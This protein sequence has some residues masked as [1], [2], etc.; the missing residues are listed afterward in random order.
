MTLH[1]HWR[2]AVTPTKRISHIPAKLAVTVAMLLYVGINYLMPFT[3]P[4]RAVTGILCPGCG[5]TRAWLAAFQLDFSAAFAHHAMF[6][7]I[8]VLYLCFLLDGSL[9]QQKWANRLF[10]GLILTG[11]LLQWLLR[12]S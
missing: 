7:S 2:K 9:F 8:P 5:L 11:F 10:Y 6:W 3:C 12:L 1:Q 4:I